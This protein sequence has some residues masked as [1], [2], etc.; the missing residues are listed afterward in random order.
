[1]LFRSDVFKS[2]QVA[3]A[4]LALRAARRRGAPF[5][6]RCGYLLSDFEARRHGA[7][8]TQAHQ[9]RVLEARVFGQADAVVVT[10]P[11]M[12]ATVITD[13]DLAA[14]RV[15][16]IPNYVET[17]R[18][19]STMAP[20]NS[21]PRIGFVGRLDQQK[22]L[23]VLLDAVSTLDVD[24]ALVGDGPQHDQLKQ[25]AATGAARV[26]F[27]GGRANEDLP[28]IMQDWD[29]FVL[30]SLYEG[31]PKALIEAMAAGLPVVGSNVIGIREIIT[32]GEN[33]L[34]AEPD[35]DSL[36]EAIQRLIQD[37]A[38]RQRLGRAAREYAV[39]HFSLDRIVELELEML[40]AVAGA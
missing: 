40:Q 15:R 33:G 13:Y 2:N 25:Q 12:R 37:S 31:H 39:Q 11:A 4:E 14:E 1:M 10:T 27:M 38:L 35:A 34:L 8:S 5:V 18:F 24:V 16:V 29:L 23:P 3:G 17:N 28:A 32:D 6:A 21:R 9:A 26:D 22:N 19:Q 36:R 20:T 7:D 30:P